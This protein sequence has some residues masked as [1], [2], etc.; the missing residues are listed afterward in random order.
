MKKQFVLFA[1]ML[2][3]GVNMEAQ[4]RLGRIV[5][6]AQQKREADTT[7]SKK[8]EKSSYDKIITKDAV[9]EKGMMDIHKV[10]SAYY[11]EIPYALLGK[12]M[13]LA[14]RVSEISAN[15]DIIAGQMPRNPFFVEWEADEDR[16][17]LLDAASK[18]VSVPGQSIVE[19]FARN[20]IK[21]V[22]K[23]FPIKAVNPDSTAVVIDVSK[24]FCGDE[25]HLSPFTPSS[26]LDGLFGV[27]RIKGSFKGDMSS[28]VGFRAFPQNILFKTR[29]VYTVSDAPFTALMTSSLVLLPDEPMRPRL[30]DDRLGIFSEVKTLYSE[31][32]DRTQRIEYINRWNL[33]PRAEDV[34]KYKRGQKVVPEKQIVYW[35]DNS[36]PEK[37]RPHLKAGIEVWQRAFEEIGFKEAI[38]A[39]DF[40]DDP[41]FDPNDIRN[42]CLIYASS[43]TANAMGP[44]WT[45]PRSGEIIQGSVYFY[46]NVLK[47]LHNWRFI[48][49]A[50]A[51]PEA[52]PEVYDMKTMGPLL[53][54]LVAHE[55]GH[56]LGLMHNMRGSYAYPVEKLRDPAFTSKYGTTA[57]IMDYARFNYVAQPGDGVKN[58]L[59]P[60][61]GPYDYF[62]IRWAYTPLFDA[63]TPEQ[64][65]LT[66]NKWLLEK[67]GDPVYQ[68]GA[69]EFLTSV[70]PASQSE[71]LGDDAVEAG[72]YGIKNL[73]VIIAN[74]KEWTAREGENYDYT[75]EM[76]E[77]VFKQFNRYMGHAS[78]YIGGNF[79]QTPVYGDNKPNFIPVDKAL[80]KK[81]L[82]F[83]LRS[84]K[85]LPEWM[86]DEKLTTLFPPNN[87][88]I[89]DYQVNIVRSLA[90][91]MTLGKVGS[92]AKNSKAP[93]TQQE[94]LDDLFNLVWEGSIAGHQITWGEQKMQ[95]AYVH[96]MLGA[97]DM[98]EPVAAAPKSL[99]ELFAGEETGL[100]CYFME[101]GRR[102][103]AT[104]MAASTKES[105]LKI[106]AK[107]LY[108]AQLRKVRQLL[109][110]LVGNTTGPLK[111]H[112]E[113]L[114]FEVDKALKNG[115]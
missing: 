44:S 103:H 101:Y 40:P 51:D 71:S 53:T 80:Q 14:G 96:T 105:D 61:L 58:F 60:A 23:A 16:V 54:Y 98:Y 6:D 107:T 82:E 77:E 56:T 2:L 108:F 5:E 43:P 94:Y 28:I 1:A 30:S 111:S 50:A 15:D 19:G 10:K 11:L 114:A 91:V 81:A 41:D 83:V 48:Q 46:H 17:Y 99:D 104:S 93:Y 79:L 33:Q 42:S 92:T 12:P 49:T 27:S 68:Y 110:G 63:A 47:L 57:S 45:D 62:I 18:A 90:S 66:L 113:Y 32:L 21:P 72:R 20:N 39:K 26:P 75:K 65:K 106:N 24:F 69:Q 8:P 84:V 87:D 34:A 38:V 78:K 3:A 102:E 88:V 97:L 85:E 31:D 37:W 76:Y 100:P 109:D 74:L 36:F 73:K 70:D 89:F 59:P 112:Y 115:M 52:R 22:M 86:L 13:L 67:S 35:V 55:I 64:E 95:Y 4:P 7:A 25:K 29:M 9:T